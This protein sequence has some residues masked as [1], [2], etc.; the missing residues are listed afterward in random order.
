[1]YITGLTHRDELF[2][3]TIRW[4]NDDFHHGDVQTISEIF[5]YESFIS[6]T[7]IVRRMLDFLKRIFG[8]LKTESAKNKGFLRECLIR[9]APHR[10]PRIDEFEKSY[11]ENPEFF[12]PRLPIDAVL[13][14]NSETHPVSIG[15][16]KRLFRV[17]EKASYR[18]IDAL[19]RE[20][21]AEATHIAEKRALEVGVPLSSLISSEEAMLQDFMDAEIAISHRFRQKNVCFTK[22]AL[23]I[24]D[25]VGFKIIG[26]QDVLGQVLE[27]LQEE[28]GFTVIERDSHTGNYNAVNVLI[29]IELPEAGELIDASRRFDWS[30]SVRRGLDPDKARQGFPA[31]IEQGARVIRMEI[32]LTTYNELM[33][34]EFGRSLHELR[35]LQLRERKAYSGLIAQNAEYLIEY[36]LSLAIAPVLDVA[37]LPIKMYGRYLP[38]T[39]SAAKHDLFGSKIDES[40]INA[41]CL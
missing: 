14:L 41:F 34:S 13:Y 20:I 28:P 17:A 12:F 26:E 22:E 2:D 38:E 32:I 9:Y 11:R 25:M 1:M 7:V 37:E 35:I 31:Y 8:D 18:L 23:A 39:L 40:L 30:M 29:D 15:R 16:T 33:E 10:S 4:L 6:A 5:L 19:F 27:L 21:I 24:N 3:L 36:L